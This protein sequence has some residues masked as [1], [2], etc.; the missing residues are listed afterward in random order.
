M[1]LVPAAFV[2]MASIGPQELFLGYDMRGM[3]RPAV[4][5][6]SGAPRLPYAFNEPAEWL[7]ADGRR[8]ATGFGTGALRLS[9]DISEP[10]TVGVDAPPERMEMLAGL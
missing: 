4:A 5:R 3:F 8:Y 1:L 9:Y 7:V 6:P 2:V 10:M